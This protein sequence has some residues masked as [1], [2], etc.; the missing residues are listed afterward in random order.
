M[1]K[2]R[3]YKS[4]RKEVFKKLPK[5]SIGI[6]FSAKTKIR[7]N[8]TEYPYRQNSNFYYLTGFKEDN[9]CLV[10]IKGKK[11]T[12][13]VLFVQ[14]KD[15][16]QELWNGKRLGKKMAKELFDVD[17]VYEN[18]ELESKLKKFLKAKKN[19]CYDFSMDKDAVKE[20]K[21][22]SSK[23]SS[24]KDISPIVNY[25][26]LV[27]SPAEIKLIKKAI[28]ITRVAHH[29]A[30]NCEKVNKKEYE[31]QALLEH[32]FKVNGAY[33]DAYSSIVASGNSANTLHYIENNQILKDGDLILIDAGCEYEYY[34]SDIT[35]T[36]PVNGEFTKAQKELYS[37]VLD[38]QLKIIKM[39]KPGV[40]RSKLQAKS[41]KLLCKGMVELGILKGDVKKLLKKQAHRKYYPHGIGHW[42]G[43]DV[44]DECPY[45]YKNGKE[46]P[47]KK[48][49]V[50]TIEPGL[51][52]DKD[53]KSIAQK[54]RG[55]GIRIE[56]NILVT[57]NGYENLSKKI[58][59][60]VNE[61]ESML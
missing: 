19:L 41:E 51:Y 15:K 6:V 47:L 18:D 56:D 22:H 57:K 37:M 2:E 3:E 1:I 23:I 7:S 54:F 10:F 40:M 61:I 52:C 9:S 26:R 27:K 14:K 25:M 32:T 44:H 8:D 24:Y 36:I 59:K 38:V 53:D 46:I 31:V 55:I 35:R 17:K 33:S 28:N 43:L 12:K 29:K 60:S 49:I 58:A 11:E 48:G 13:T 45:K 30:M 21:K 39:I 42:L 50:L 34:A 5:N 20:L 16:V 4:R